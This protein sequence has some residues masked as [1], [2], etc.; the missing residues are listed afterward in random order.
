MKNSTKWSFGTNDPAGSLEDLRYR[1]SALRHAVATLASNKNRQPES[2]TEGAANGLIAA[3]KQLDEIQTHPALKAV[4]TAG[5]RLGIKPISTFPKTA[6]KNEHLRDASS[7]PMGPAGRRDRPQDWTIYLV[8][9]AFALG[10]VASPFMAS[11]LPTELKAQTPTISTAPL[12][13]R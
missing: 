6:K 10:L 11:R 5:G 7:T 8:I 2:N 3:L 12:P 1:L 9:I 13:S 4:D